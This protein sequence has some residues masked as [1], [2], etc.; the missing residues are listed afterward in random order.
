LR[1]AKFTGFPAWVVWASVHIYFLI[2]FA[3]RLFVLLQWGFDFLS[4]RRQV[5]VLP[6]EPPAAQ[7]FIDPAA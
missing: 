6:V 5:R 3:N 7:T 1:F 4:K 2:G